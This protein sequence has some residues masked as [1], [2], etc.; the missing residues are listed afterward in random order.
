MRLY[1]VSDQGADVFGAGW[2]TSGSSA[3]L[4]F[5]H[6]LKPAG[7][8]GLQAH[9]VIEYLAMSL[10]C[11]SGLEAPEIA[12]IATPDD[13]PQTLL[14]QRFDIRTSSDHERRNLLWRIYVR[15]S[16]KNQKRSIMEQ[17]IG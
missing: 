9:P 7:I 4:T 2:S 15:L 10:G 3:C 5:T 1:G 13:F 16:S 17:S 8:S 12:L 6:I 11:A 14:V